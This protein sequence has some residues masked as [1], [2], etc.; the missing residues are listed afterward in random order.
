LL[1]DFFAIASSPSE[2]VG[3]RQKKTAAALCPAAGAGKRAD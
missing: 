3:V 2:M 1:P